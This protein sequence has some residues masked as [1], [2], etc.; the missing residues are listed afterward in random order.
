[1]GSS[2][3]TW[4]S[5]SM[6]RSSSRNC[7]RPWNAWSP[8]AARAWALANLNASRYA[9]AIDGLAEAQLA[10]RPLL[11]VGRRIGGELKAMG[12]SEADP[13]SARIGATLQKLFA[14][15]S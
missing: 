9:E 4:S 6:A 5:R 2:L 11:A 14:P 3:R 8:K 10:S 13:A 15:L 12:V 1:M 7:A